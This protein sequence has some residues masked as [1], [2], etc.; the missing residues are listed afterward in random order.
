MR[1]AV[2]QG[3]PSAILLGGFHRAGCD[4]VGIELVVTR[5]SVVVSLGFVCGDRLVII[6]MFEMV[7]LF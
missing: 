6:E 3:A 4:L 7:F 5:E 1:S 2:A